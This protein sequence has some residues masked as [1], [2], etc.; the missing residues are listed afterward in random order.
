MKYSAC[1][2]IT[3][4]IIFLTTIMN[5]GCTSDIQ[6]KTYYVS[7]EGNDDN[8]GLSTNT[9]WASIERV[10]RET[11]QPGDDILLESGGVWHGQMRPL[12]SGEPGKPII[13]SSYG[14]GA[15]PVIN[16]GEEEGCGI[17]LVNQSWWEI[18]GIEITS[19]A[20]P[21]LGVKRGAILA[22]VE[23]EGKQIEHIVIR[24]C[25]IHDIWGQLGGE[26]TS[27]AI[28]VGKLGR[29]TP[30]CTANDILV[31]N[32]R[33]E[34]FDKVGIRIRG[35]NRIIV[36]G[37]Y[38]K[39]LGGDGIIV[40]GAYRALI[41]RNIADRT[42]LRTGDLDLDT[43]GETWWPHTAAIWLA[44]C[45]ETVMQF[46]EVYNTGRQPA[47]GD[48][49]AYDFDHGCKECI[50][51]YNYSAY[52]RG[53]FLLFMDDA[54][55]CVARYNISQN[56]QTHLIDIWNCNIANQNMIHNN[57]FYVDHGTV[58][59]EYYYYLSGE[60]KQEKSELGVNLRN[61]IFYST[62]QGR[63]RTVYSY[64]EFPG[65]VNRAA[66]RKYDASVKLPPPV[67]GTRFYRNCYFGPWLN[68]LPDDPEKLVADPL[69][70]EPGGGGIGLSSLDGYKL[71][72]GSP[73]IDAGVSI[74]MNSQRDFYGNPVNDG[75][76]DMGVYEQQV[77]DQ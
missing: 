43:G 25:Y 52:N 71:K 37:N 42:C 63:F 68:G 40:S 64:D 53:G 3:G 1:S 61:N 73:C 2:F 11:F 45:I 48:G 65:D 77:L 67:H 55:R 7:P 26:K 49:M 76:I 24:D 10:N 33:I 74:E 15:K 16:I 46:N 20:Q 54:F 5:I 12:G 75:S 14:Q 17:T 30:N 39:N 57:V 72:P 44:G 59:I 62:G 38:M 4:L 19:G 22:T 31:E 32:N 23:G 21:E 56:D 13:I 60:E 50:L 66:T 8:T 36:R 35:D 69:L 28:Y 9:A 70:V 6:S 29:G 58:D 47:N 18:Q 51:Q 41:E 34:R 27:I